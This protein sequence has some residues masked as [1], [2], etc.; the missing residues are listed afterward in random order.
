[1]IRDLLAIVDNATVAAP[2]LA[3]A[4]AL[5]ELHD[6]HLEIAALTP[7]PYFAPQLLPLGAM[8]V[9]DEV[10]ARDD[11]AKVEAVSALVS[12]SKTRSSVF[13]LHDDVAWLAGDV[14]RSRQLADLVLIGSLE[15]WETPW[16]RRRVIE[17]A[18]VSS[19]TPTIILPPRKGLARVSRAVLG[20]KPSPEANRAVHDLVAIAEP[21]AAV[22]IVIVDQKIE[23]DA[24]DE[25][26]RHLARHGL[27]PQ[28]HRLECDGVPEAG[29]LHGFAL[30]SAADLLVVG[31]FAHSRLREI[32]LGGVTRTLIEETEV[33]VLLS[34]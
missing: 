20:W 30:R 6:A 23:R 11:K 10:L 31:G 18:I 8:Y 16:L 17:T 22:E 2:F 3:H 26:V 32:V 33:P 1:M 28:L 14:R 25:V 7:S 21:G 12:A 9:P 29:V 24:G 19:G 13:G 4:L 34:H 15:E 27:K 5:G